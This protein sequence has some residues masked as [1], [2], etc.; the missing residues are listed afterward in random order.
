MRT[1][2]VLALGLVAGCTGSARQGD[3][4]VADLVIYGCT[5]AGLTAA[6]TA[7]SRDRSVVLLCPERHVGG[8]TTNGLGWADTGN[9]AAIG[10]MARRFYQDVKTHYQA[11]GFKGIATSQSKT[12]GEEDAM[13]VF[14]PHVAETIYLR[15]LKDAGIEPVFNAKLR[16]DSSAVEKRD[17]Q[18]VSIQMLDG[19]RYTGRVFVDATYEGDLMAMAGVSFTTGREGNAMY[20]E[21]YNGVQTANAEQHN[22]E[23]DIDPYVKPGDRSSGLVPLVEPGPPGEQGAGDKRIQAYN[24]RLCMTKDPAN[25]APVPKPADYDP[26]TY[27]LLGRYLDAGWRHKFRKFDPIPNNKTDVN[28]YGAISTDF[29]GGNYD[30]PTAGYER[31]RQIFEAHKN[32]QSGLIWFMQNDPRVPTDV[33]QSMSEWGLCADEFVD[34]GHWP[35]EMYV[36]EARRMV[37]DFVMTERHLEGQLPTPRSVGLG[38]YTM[39]SHNVQRYVNADGFARNEGDVQIHLDRTYEISYDAIVPRAAESTNLFVPVAVSASHIAYGSIRMEPVFMILG[40][41]VGEAA[42]LAIEQGVRVQ[43]VSYEKLAARL[44]DRGQLIDPVGGKYVPAPSR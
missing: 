21:D 4:K 13:W 38:S 3:A 14:E 5:P 27:E 22:F 6:I 39:D 18:I 12:E 33:R 15:W 1:L 8:M 36:R 31:R 7:K 30:Y 24:F 41:S 20:G 34:N 28:N 32:Y 17:Q 37:S 35:R 16:L 42:V 9:H 2:A 25:R 40:Q 10:G 23:I 43:D 29:I 19:A 44:R 11:V 26:W